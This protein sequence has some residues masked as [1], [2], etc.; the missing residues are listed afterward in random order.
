MNKIIAIIG[1]LALANATWA[2]NPA[3]DDASDPAYGA[4]WLN[5]SN[6]GTGFGPWQLSTFGTI[7]GHFIGHSTQNADGLDDGNVNG[8]ANDNDITTFTGPGQPV[9]WGMY[10]DVGGNQAQA[11][12]PFT[13]GP[14]TSG[15][16]FSIN[17]DNGYIEPGGRII[18]GLLDS[19][20]TPVFQVLFTGGSANYDYIDGSGLFTTGMGYGDEGLNLT[21]QMTGATSYQA[22]LS[23]FDGAVAN[24]SGT[25]NAAPEA[26]GAVSINVGQG[27]PH[28]FFINSMSIVP[29]PSTIALG[30]LGVAGVALRALRRR[31]SPHVVG[32][33]RVG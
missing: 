26:F 33:Q 4:G 16:I 27:F 13:G 24:W 12:R 7:A 17:F 28:D 8:T 23:R 14:L 20:N 19:G 1:A 6:G 2:A 9:A 32:M 21:V 29:E 31:N 18:V 3:S 11:I 25:M 22:T 5:G 10:A 30:A 15:Q